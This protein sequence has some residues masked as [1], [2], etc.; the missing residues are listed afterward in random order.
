MS[1]YHRSYV[2]I[3]SD[4]YILRNAIRLLFF[5]WCECNPF[6]SF[7]DYIGQHFWLFVRPYVVSNNKKHI[8]E[9][10]ILRLR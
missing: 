6:M 4:N 5:F 10:L 3:Y 2:I 8:L 7:D 9:A 1:N